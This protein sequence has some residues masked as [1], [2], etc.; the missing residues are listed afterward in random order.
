[1][2]AM[3]MP[4]TINRLELVIAPYRWFAETGMARSRPRTK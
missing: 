1:M 4:V 2:M 3:Q